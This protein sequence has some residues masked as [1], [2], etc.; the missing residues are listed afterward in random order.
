MS[1]T[2][3]NEFYEVLERYREK[4]CIKHDN[5]T[6]TYDELNFQSDIV[7]KIILSKGITKESFIGVLV[8]DKVE[9]IVI[10]LG[11][12]KAG[13]VFVPLDMNYPVKRLCMMAQVTGL[14]YIF[15][16]NKT[17]E[18]LDKFS[19][20]S[21]EIE[22]LQLRDSQGC[23]DRRHYCDFDLT[24]TE[25]NEEQPIYV[26]FTSGSTGKPKAIVGKNGSLLH[27]IKWEI[28]TFEIESGTKIS[29]FTS[30][31]HDPYLRDIFVPLFSGGIIVIPPSK[32]TILESSTLI[33]WIDS[34]K[35]NLIHCT[36]SL[37][38]VFNSK[39]L[40]QEHFRELQY[41]LLAGEKINPKE[42]VNWYN[43][44]GN[45]IKLIN[46]YGP[47]ETTLAKLYYII[48]PEDAYKNSVPVG[49]PIKG[50]RAVIVDD[51][52]KMCPIGVA[53]EII[54][55]TPYR[56]LGYYNSPDMNAERFISNPFSNDRN[57]IVYRTGDIGKLLPD[58]NI[59]FVGRKDRQVKIRG[60]RI[61]LDDIEKVLCNN[62]AV[63]EAAVIMKNFNDSAVGLC[64][65]ITLN[66]ENN[67]AF[68]KLNKEE[69]VTS[70]G[71]N[72]NTAAIISEVKSYVKEHLPDYMVPQYIT[73]LDKMPVNE[74]KK[75]DY[76]AL[77]EP[78]R[79][80]E[81][82]TAPRDEYEKEIEKIWSELLNIENIGI[83][84]NFM[85][86]GGHSLNMMT[87]IT[88]INQA[89]SVKVQLA[90][91]FNNP[92][93]EGMAEIVK[94]SERV[95][96]QSILPVEKKDYYETSSA[97][98]RMFTLSQFEPGST[99]YNISRALVI[100]APVDRDKCRKAFEE[101][102]ERHEILRTSFKL[103]DGEIYQVINP[104]KLCFTYEEVS[105]EQVDSKIS[106]F[107][108]PFELN[109]S[110]LFRCGLFRVS[111][112]KSILVMDIHHIIAD[113][114]S[115][116]I[117][118][119]EFMLLYQGQKLQTLRI[120]YKDFANWQNK[121]LDDIKEQKK[122][123]L[124][125]F[126][127][128]IPV[129][130]M[131][132]DFPRPSVLGYEGDRIEFEVNEE[133]VAK[134]RNVLN[135][136]GVTLYMF[137]LAAYNVLL[138][139]YTSQEDIVVGTPIA[140]RTHADL[141]NVIGM[142]VNTLAMRNKP[143]AD[144]TF[145]E[146]L[147]AVKDNSLNA[148]NNQDY[149]LEQLI[150]NLDLNRDM[151]RNT[152]IE[153]LFTLQNT[154]SEVF[155][156][157]DAKVQPYNIGEVKA[158]FELSLD[159]VE[160]E[161]KIQFV[162][163]FSTLLYKRETM[164]RF[165]NHFINILKEVASNLDTKI[166]DIDFLDEEEK[167]KILFDFNKTEGYFPN[168]K[169]VKDLF[170]EQ[171]LKYP[172]K[173]AVVF[174]EQSITY[175]QL[176]KR[177]NQLARLL[178][179]KGVKP[180]NIVPVM[181][182]RSIDV[183][184]AIL[185]VIKAGGAYLP[186]DPMYPDDRIRYMFSDSDAKILLTNKSL[187][188][189]V[190][191]ESI[192]IDDEQIDGYD[193]SSLENVN[194]PSDLLYIIYTSGTTGKP[195]GV[196]IEH[197]N[198][199]NITYGWKT[200]YNLDEM[201][202]SLL[203]L[204]S[205]SFDVFAGDLSRSLLNG[206][207]MVICPDDT[208][209]EIKGIYNLIN[210]HKITIM[211]S[212]PGLIIPLMD[213]IY[214]NNLTVDSLKLLI[215]GSDVLRQEDFNRISRRFNHQMRILNSYGVTEAAIDSSYFE[216]DSQTDCCSVNLPIGRP[217]LNNKFYILDKYGRIQPIGVP[218][219]LYIG[220]EGV[221]RGYYKREELTNEKFVED[222]FQKG[223]KMYR[224]GDFARWLPDGNIEFFGRMD[225]QIKVR[226]YRIEI[227]EIENKL[228]EIDKVREAAVVLRKIRGID[229]LCAYVTASEELTSSVI[230]ELLLKELPE[231]MV[232]S[233]IELLVQLPQTPNGKI[234]RKKLS[235]I[236]LVSDSVYEKPQNE[237]EERI[238]GIWKEVLN[239]EN[240]STND[241]FFDLGGHSIKAIELT[242]KL[243][244]IGY[245]IKV[246]DIFKNQTIKAL[247]NYIEY[248]IADK[249]LVTCRDLLQEKIK[250]KF[251]IDS[252]LV[253]LTLKEGKIEVLLLSA[254]AQKI[255][256]EL[257]EYIRDNISMSI[258]PN[259]I[260]FTD[261]YNKDNL[262]SVDNINEL[263]GLVSY[264]SSYKEDII[265]KLQKSEKLFIDKLLSG[266]QVRTYPL[267][268]VQEFSAKFRQNSGCVIKF[269]N[270]IDI[271]IFEKA[272]LDLVKTQGLL[273]SVLTKESGK[274]MWK[275][276]GS[277]DCLP[278]DFIDVSEFDM[279]SQKQI[280]KIIS[281]EFCG[282][283]TDNYNT[284][285]YRIA[286]VKLNLKEHL[287]IMGCDH[288]IFDAAS[289]EV[290]KRELLKF[291]N[292]YKSLREKEN[293]KG[294]HKE[295]GSV[296]EKDYFHYIEQISKGP[297]DINDEELYLK[298]KLDDYK[299]WSAKLKSCMKKYKKQK[300]V[301]YNFC[302]D[303]EMDKINVTPWELSIGLT[304]SF[305][306]KLFCID[307]IP[308]WI[309]NYGRCYQ[310]NEYQDIVGEFV[311]AFPAIVEINKDNPKSMSDYISE[312]TYFIQNHNVS[313]AALAFS[314][315]KRR[316]K[317]MDS[318]IKGQIFS[319]FVIFNFQGSFDED[320]L[321][322]DYLNYNASLDKDMKK[323]NKINV[324]ASY[325]KKSLNLAIT[326]PFELDNRVEME[327]FLV[328]EAKVLLSSDYIALYK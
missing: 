81:N 21:Y 266:Q 6:L 325:S 274:L 38:K 88:R 11:I 92:T 210:T 28:E 295:I 142:F 312:L 197:R 23:I 255:K 216:K 163:E 321:R 294:L 263:L 77:P 316:Y 82:Y 293:E 17:K 302:I 3:Q 68:G 106:Q 243:E 206:G 114:T 209:L 16:D 217:M 257:V 232:P 13:C 269:D 60:F 120:Q 168:N 27:F 69:Y 252:E 12:I 273:R 150:N 86:L 245:S 30:Q 194:K 148:F 91:V 97:Q 298:F 137:L 161:N 53:G 36:P 52:L 135:K 49:K 259:Y 260:L 224:T 108:K 240:I 132:T 105:E 328:N 241:N 310:N 196:M 233:H 250:E 230:K 145:S 99:S 202:I 39:M 204:A 286:F 299:E 211:E 247:A 41:V 189:K 246:T 188:K 63:K 323:I 213:Y 76:R 126:R 282:K 85:D 174:R 100:Q 73:V 74:N 8:D 14:R 22:G 15:T 62:E 186:I 151:S 242:I 84:D 281:E 116:E 301:K 7:A 300:S 156:L 45:R 181:I 64:A 326:L 187:N 40:K 141:K 284:P 157:G 18:I 59:E 191:F 20:E 320:E 47:T 165:A 95:S 129:L 170:E 261:N 102:V 253:D 222:N 180:N 10:M 61:E 315:I 66:A 317:K 304:M 223:K 46:L 305:F 292:A 9:Q 50:A 138:S 154:G 303:F 162:L 201:D 215:L 134:I 307:R 130:G 238:L 164:E 235:Q 54:I 277:C 149:P 272:F 218:G 94:N 221:A 220:G 225:N 227:G 98:K 314:N 79:I 55:R 239:I 297:V 275:E 144:L 71:N 110:P 251:F 122:Y 72:L 327:K 101:L 96:E 104:P 143:E 208:K 244:K 262:S 119:R 311:D 35:I 254:S 155:Q 19:D 103:I 306:G 136:T 26:Y 65:Y 5:K 147:M 51:N 115:M 319:Q 87:L 112:D 256:L 192:E 288:L 279:D 190:E 278:F 289:S 200:A 29:Q 182:E 175:G 159:A 276:Y 195:K 140:G 183:I 43:T 32:E 177:T 2:I 318:F 237:L 153:T 44:F 33:S 193:E 111:D 198:Y 171:A 56:T 4:I 207:K 229:L 78:Q 248:Y 290:I 283:R 83:Y 219:E 139:K 48:S 291:Y 109:E 199:V 296:I 113:G 280:I 203:Q 173:V 265:D 67:E 158:K 75:L 58:G 169:T 212:T 185:A 309:L 267:S 34:E 90:D 313:F 287:L 123:W 234:D 118:V 205:I 285:C 1:S 131:P 226:G 322:Y 236:E 172:D 42:L 268:P 25:Y 231:Y 179:E 93:I 271:R 107:V 80:M 178:R 184:I 128:E 152:L 270:Y 133:V 214:E 121:K 124:D 249:E 160:F 264:N 258:A 57:D 176:D 127:D 324:N 31:C 125:M 308:M 167:R 166:S 117:F 228:I 70:T 37:Y 89:F 24:N 146:F